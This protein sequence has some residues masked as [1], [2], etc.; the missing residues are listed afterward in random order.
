MVRTE[1]QKMKN[2]QKIEETFICLQT[3]KLV[4][5]KKML[6]YIGQKSGLTEFIDRSSTNRLRKHF[7]L[8]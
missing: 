1:N 4:D 7:G 2:N 3:Y 8:W 6:E 5:M